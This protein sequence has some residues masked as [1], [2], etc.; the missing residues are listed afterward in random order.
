MTIRKESFRILLNLLNHKPRPR[1]LPIRTIQSRRELSDG[2]P[3][4]DS[5]I[6]ITNCVGEGESWR[7]RG[8]T[9]SFAD[10]GGG[11]GG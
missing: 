11:F 4:T 8:T 7:L 2:K 10:V 6:I 9:C 1:I 3:S 5:S